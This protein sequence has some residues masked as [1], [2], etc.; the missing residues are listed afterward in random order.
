MYYITQKSTIILGEIFMERFIKFFRT[1]LVILSC[2]I[3]IFSIFA[4]VYGLEIKDSELLP[5]LASSILNLFLLVIYWLLG[6]GYI[7]PF[8]ILENKIIKTLSK[9]GFGGN[10]V[11]LILSILIIIG[12]GV[13]P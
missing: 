5:I 4:W 2:I 3:L 13:I 10:I 9:L 11:M 6:I 1:L 12:F 7:K 8:K